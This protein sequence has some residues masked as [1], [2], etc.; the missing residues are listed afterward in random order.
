M[1]LQFDRATEAD[2]PALIALLSDDVLGAGREGLDEQA[3]YAR[4]F[5]Q[6]QC[7]PNQFLCVAKDRDH[8]VGTLQLSFVQGLSRRGARR[9][10]IEAVRVA[11]DRRG[12][13]VGQAMMEW[14]I[15][16]C[17]RQGC[18]LVQLTTDRSRTDAHRFYDRLGFTASH[19]GY[20]LALD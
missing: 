7:D 18:A 4:A 3:V 1:T 9:G 2:L 8:V 5:A 14:A 20:K 12:Q 16:E 11:S 13:G 15:A 17:R 6:I 10:L 19:V